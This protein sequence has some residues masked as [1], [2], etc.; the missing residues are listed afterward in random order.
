[1]AGLGR[2]RL[3]PRNHLHAVR[4]RRPLTTGSSGRVTRSERSSLPVLPQAGGAHP[5]ATDGAPYYPLWSPSTLRRRSNLGRARQRGCLG[6]S[7]P[8]SARPRMDATAA[9]LRGSD[10]SQRRAV[11]L[12]RLLTDGVGPTH[13]ITSCGV[14]RHLTIPQG[15]ASSLPQPYPRSPPRDSPLSIP[16]RRIDKGPGG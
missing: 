16:L 11:E 13:A 14:S 1:M 3:C 15:A 8:W 4:R 10:H 6:A 7:T 9:Q 5:C 2:G 12:D